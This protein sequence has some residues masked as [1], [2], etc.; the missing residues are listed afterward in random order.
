MTPERW[1]LI[2]KLFEAALECQPPERAAFLDT[3]CAD[4]EELRSEVESLLAS[5]ERTPAFMEATPTEQMADLFDNSHAEEGVGQLFDHY[6]ILGS[7]GS[8]GMG[9]VYLA[10]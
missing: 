4:D 2:D 3:A 6:K 8:G 9:E 10:E 7:L 5:H 1:Q